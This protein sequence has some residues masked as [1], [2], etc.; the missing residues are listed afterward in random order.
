MDFVRFYNQ[1]ACLNNPK[2]S[3]VSLIFIFLH[4]RKVFEL[5]DKK[6]HKIDTSDVLS[7]AERG[8]IAQYSFNTMP[9]V[10]FYKRSLEKVYL[11]LDARSKKRE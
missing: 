9:A 8:R 6:A 5:K 11:L 7:G 2:L 1:R 10:V 4:L 3:H